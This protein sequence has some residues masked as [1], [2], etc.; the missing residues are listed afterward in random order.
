MNIHISN[1][2]L[3]VF[4]QLIFCEAL[5]L[6][7]SEKR[8]HFGWLAALTLLD[9]I[10]LM[11][12]YGSLVRA[13]HSDVLRIMGYFVA[14]LLAGVCAYG[15]FSITA[16]SA[17]FVASGSYAIQHM[18]FT[19]EG[20]LARAVDFR[21]LGL[22]DLPAIAIPCLWAL[23]MY[24]MLIRRNRAVVY[25]A[26]IRQLLIS[27][28]L[29][30]LCI[31]LS[32]VRQVEGTAE[33]YVHIY[34]FI[35]C[36]S[37][38]MIQFSIS[39][40]QRIRE[41]N[42]MLATVINKQHEQHEMSKQAVEMLNIKFHDIRSQIVNL[43]KKLDA[44]DQ[45]QVEDVKRTLQIYESMANT[46]NATIDAILMEKGLM[47]EINQIRFSYIADGR[48]MDFMAA[49]DVFSLLN[50][51]LDNAVE[52]E[53]REENTERRMVSLRIIRINETILL[54]VE[55][56]CTAPVDLQQE[57][58]PTTKHDKSLHGIGMKGIRFVVDKYRGTMRFSQENDM[59]HVSIVFPAEA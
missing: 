43:Q 42:R 20:I 18:G 21:A 35:T 14:W 31:V 50:N 2:V 4:C 16:M 30:M 56:Y 58:L 12:A 52:R 45:Q 5:F 37:C 11:F 27:G 57:V 7:K 24:W 38:L 25:N 22:G 41:E 36:L 51:L 55:N 9:S 49:V 23:A 44:E 59:F 28:V 15:C 26:D 54:D 3:T 40:G 19:V 8:K 32:F 46:G 34:D 39:N 10:G 33:L 13:V 53:L 6:F 17:V 1:P 29:L 48:Q 47:C